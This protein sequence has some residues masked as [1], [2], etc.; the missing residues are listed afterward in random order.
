MHIKMNAELMKFGSGLV[1]VGIASYTII[2]VVAE[3]GTGMKLRSDCSFELGKKID[4]GNE[5]IL[6]EVRNLDTKICD[7]KTH[8]NK[9]MD[10][11]SSNVE[12]SNCNSKDKSGIEIFASAHN[13]NSY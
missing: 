1:A 9:R 6:A 4:T 10:D 5:K 2:S 12:K 11:L 7:L 13:L 8:M 3:K